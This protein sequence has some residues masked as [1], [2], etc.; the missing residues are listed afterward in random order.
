MSNVK[1]LPGAPTPQNQP[2]AEVVEALKRA[3][4]RAESGE[5]RSVAI[6]SILANGDVWHK[7]VVDDESFK[8]LGAIEYMKADYLRRCGEPRKKQ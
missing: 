1:Q 3:L 5:L 6:T 2:V 7:L 4:A 8:M